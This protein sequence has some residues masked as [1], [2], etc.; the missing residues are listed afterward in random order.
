MVWYTVVTIKANL[1]LKSYAV[2]EW[3]CIMDV[4]EFKTFKRDV[5]MEHKRKKIQNIVEF[6][7]PDYGPETKM[8]KAVELARGLLWVPEDFLFELSFIKLNF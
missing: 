1:S 4:G 7:A 5:Q 6:H 2:L 3:E 8:T